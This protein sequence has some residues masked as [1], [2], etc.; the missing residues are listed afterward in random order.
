LK[1]E[2]SK[3]EFRNNDLVDYIATPEKLFHQ[4]AAAGETQAE[5]D[6]KY[7]LLANLPIQYHPF[8]TSICNNDDYDT[9][10]YD[11]I[12]DHLILKHQQL[13]GST[14]QSNES[15]E[16]KAFLGWKSG[17]WKGKGKD[18]GNAGQKEKGPSHLGVWIKPAACIARRK[19]IG[20]GDVLKRKGIRKRIAEQEGMKAA[21][22]GQ[23]QIPHQPVETFKRGPR[24]I[25][26]QQNKFNQSGS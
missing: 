17:G 22:V 14:K 12:C 13:T 16:S 11:K 25:L 26:C 4:L 2:L 5:K 21:I 19:G 1:G 23:G 20:H 10:T 6:K 15:K 8:H 18:Y 3:V 7:L 9:T 24:W